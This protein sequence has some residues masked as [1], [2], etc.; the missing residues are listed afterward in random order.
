MSS[1]VSASVYNSEIEFSSDSQA[2]EI[3][4]LNSCVLDLNASLL[5]AAVEAS[6]VFILSTIGM[7]A[8]T[9]CLDLSPTNTF[10]TEFSKLIL[11]FYFNH[12]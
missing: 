8:L 4:D 5:K 3:I 10:S 9:S 1:V 11:G 6:K 2:S 12:L 7:I